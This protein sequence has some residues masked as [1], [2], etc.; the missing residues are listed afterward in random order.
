MDITNKAVAHRTFGEGIVLN[1]SDTVITV[2][3]PNM[4]QKRFEYPEAF[5]THL[6]LCE[7]SLHESVC[8]EA[9][10]KAQRVKREKL[11]VRMRQEKLVFDQEAAAKKP[12][13]KPPKKK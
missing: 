1:Q 3:F 5:V 4:K 10:Q 13:K 6:S 11:R 8:A 7:P 2:S 12:V 9:R